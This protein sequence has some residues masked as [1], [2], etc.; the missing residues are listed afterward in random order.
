M[1]YVSYCVD[2][3]FTLMS[4]VVDVDRLEEIIERGFMLT[5]KEQEAFGAGL[6]SV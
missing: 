3:L 6:R 5:D 4:E 2:P 1:H